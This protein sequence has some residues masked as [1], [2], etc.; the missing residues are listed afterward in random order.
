MV[1]SMG[2]MLLG[3]KLYLTLA[4][5]VPNDGQLQATE[6]IGLMMIVSMMDLEFAGLEYWGD[7]M[8]NRLSTGLGSSRYCQRSPL[9]TMNSSNLCI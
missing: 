2:C 5:K 7:R 1:P 3:A 9:H 4:T 6:A 8:P